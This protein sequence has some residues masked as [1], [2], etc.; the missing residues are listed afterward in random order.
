MA[1]TIDFYDE[2]GLQRDAD[3]E[4]IRKQLARAKLEFMA[5]AQRGG[6]M[7]SVWHQKLEVLRQVE[8]DGIF[9]DEDARDRYDA[10]LRRTDPPGEAPIDWVER[11]STYIANGDT[12]AALIAARKAK[13]QAPDN[14]M[15]YV[16][17]AEA[18]LREGEPKQAKRDADEAFV[19]GENGEDLVNVLVAR[20]Q[21]FD[22]LKEHSRAAASLAAAIKHADVD[23]KPDLYLRLADIYLTMRRPADAYMAARDGLSQRVELADDAKM[24]RLRST[25]LQAI[26]QDVGSR[27]KTTHLQ[28]YSDYLAQIALVPMDRDSK[29]RVSEYLKKNIDRCMRR[30]RFQ[31]E[32]DRLSKFARPDGPQPA[33]PWGAIQLAAVALV[34]GM[35]FFA[36]SPGLGMVGIAVAIVSVI[37]ACMIGTQRNEWS[38][39]QEEYESAQRALESI[40]RDL[41]GMDGPS[42]PSN[43][44]FK[45]VIPE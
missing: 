45:L 6:S 3:T 20:A 33:K 35:I 13:E 28:R 42:G 44:G 21:V 15:A 16:A 22:A 43:A 29:M 8:A 9:A 18:W 23:A 2:L 4:A 1:S 10:S 27:P 17:S 14:P 11:A 26:N 12:G 7:R 38:R 19:L 5:K 30:E 31:E 25:L 32:R 41:R 37:Y 24:S 36:F 40:D 39:V 34:I